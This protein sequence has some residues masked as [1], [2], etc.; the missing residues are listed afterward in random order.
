MG[1]RKS[2]YFDSQ[3]ERHR[4]RLGKWRRSLRSYP[5]SNNPS[6]S[7]DWEGHA[8]TMLTAK[9]AAAL[10]L[11]ELEFVRWLG[12]Y[13]GRRKPLI[14]YEVCSVVMVQNAW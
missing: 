13:S 1:L 4:G 3:L 12:Y 5:P 8:V 9:Q 2:R 6:S 11:I 10:G 14:G 7:R